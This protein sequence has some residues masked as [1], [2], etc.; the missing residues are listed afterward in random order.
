[1]NLFWCSCFRICS[2]CSKT[3]SLRV[4]CSLSLSSKGKRSLLLI[5]CSS[6]WSAPGLSSSVA[7]CW[8]V[9]WSVCNYWELG[10]NN[11][12]AP[13]LPLPEA[14]DSP[15]SLHIGDEEWWTAQT[16]PPPGC[17][18]HTWCQSS[19]TWAVLGLHMQRYQRQK[20]CGWGILAWRRQTSGPGEYWEQNQ[21]SHC[22]LRGSPLWPDQNLLT[23][24]QGESL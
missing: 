16:A 8:L 1:M 21:R 4:S 10:C 24:P 20:C 9:S 15:D 14:G 18:C 22:F 17:T 19:H 3:C 13:W 12:Q 23:L 11:I 2:F 5:L 6:S 7:W